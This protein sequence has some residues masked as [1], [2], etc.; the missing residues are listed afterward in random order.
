MA[1][2]W[3]VFA[4]CAATVA[5]IAAWFMPV[6]SWWAEH[7][8]RSVPATIALPYTVCRRVSAATAQRI[9]TDEN[10]PPYIEYHHGRLVILELNGGAHDS[11]VAELGLALRR[12][13]KSS[14]RPGVKV[15]PLYGNLGPADARKPDL[16]IALYHGA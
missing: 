11:M 15:R 8:V 6:P 12:A 14:V 9:L 5:A 4:V 3:W 2:L 10:T 16:K 7:K 1:L 13:L